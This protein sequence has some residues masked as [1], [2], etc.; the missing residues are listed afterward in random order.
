MNKLRYFIQQSWLLMASA[1]FFG[2]LIAIANAA[3][4]PIIERNKAEKLARLMRT[5]L[6]DATTFRL[7]EK[8]TIKSQRGEKQVVALYRGLSDANET[9]GWAFNA[10]GPGFQDKIELVLAV[11]PAFEKYAG[12]AVL[13]SNETPGFGDKIKT[14]YFREQFRAAPAEPLELLKTGDDKKIDSQ[15]VA[16][17]GA[18]VSSESVVNLVNNT[19][20][21]I[22]QQMKQK[23]LLPDGR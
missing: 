23:G 9:I 1:F 8:L 10:S 5:L 18:T 16:I 17:T 22:K 11:D 20:L 2:L 14:P 7:Q 13:S 4:S 3:W 19:A 6:P 15:I 12:F 21:Q